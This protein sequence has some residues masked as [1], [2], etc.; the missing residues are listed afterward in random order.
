MNVFMKRVRILVT[1]DRNIGQNINEWLHLS[2]NG[3]RQFRRRDLC[4]YLARKDIELDPHR[5]SET[6]NLHFFPVNYS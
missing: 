5:S 2:Q 4:M 1:A 3:F 6:K